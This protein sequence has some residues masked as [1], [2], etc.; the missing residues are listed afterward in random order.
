MPEYPIDKTSN[1]IFQK[2]PILIVI[3][4]SF[5]LCYQHFFAPGE[6][7]PLQPG[8]FSE[9][10]EVPLD[11]FNWGISSYPLKVENYLIF[12]NY[13][14]RAP[15]PQATK[16]YFF[17]AVTGLLISLGITLITTF[18]RY[19]FIGGMGLVIVLLTLSG[20]NALNIGGVSSNLSLIIL[21]VGFTIPGMIIH[22][23]YEHISLL[24]RS[25]IIIPIIWLTIASLLSLS[26][27]MNPALLFSENIGLT[28]LGIAAIFLLY[29]GHAVVGSFFLLL[30]KL[31]RGVGLKISWHITAFTMVY[32][33]LLL[34]I[35]LHHTGSFSLP[36][37]YPPLFPLALLAGYLGWFEVKAKLDQ[38]AQPFDWTIVGSAFYW[39][40]FGITA[41]VFWKADFS[42]NEPMQDF[43]DHWLLYTQ[44]AMS[45]LFFFY[46]MANFLGFMNSGKP[47]D[48][49]IFKPKYFAYLHMRIGSFIALLSLIVYA[50]GVIAPQLSTS[51][52]NFSADYYY[53]T[54][55]PLEARIL[56]ENSWIRY[57][58]NSKAKVATA[59]LYE[60]E[61]QLTLAKQ[62]MEE[63]FEW[64]PSVAEVLLAANMAHKRNRYF[65]ALF[66]LE[67]GLEMFPNN[68][69]I[70]NNL[71]LLYSKSNK[72]QQAL[73]LLED[74]ANADPT[75]LANQIGLQVKHLLRIESM[76]TPGKNK[77]AKI[78]SLAYENVLG[79][80]AAFSLTA[81]PL[82]A[83]L[84]Q[85]AILRNQW[86]NQ[87]TA[88]LAQDI[89]LVDSLYSH[90]QHTAAQQELR[91]TR[92][93]RSYQAHHIG[94]T[95]KYL[96]GLAID[97]NGSA[98]Y[99]HA[100]AA[101]ILT[102]EADFEKA[103]NELEM[104]EMMGFR[105]LK[106]DHLPILYFG[107]K[108]DLSFKIADKYDLEFPKWMATEQ[109]PATNST[110]E[111]LYFGH[112]AGLNKATKV[113]F[114]AQL[115]SMEGGPLKVIFAHE[116]LF[117]K[118]HWLSENEIEKISNYL[119]SH[120]ELDRHYIQE[121]V[122]IAR[123]EMENSPESPLLKAYF[124][125]NAPVSSNPYFTPV[126]LMAA[127]T[128]SSAEAR[129]EL[130]RSAAEF[131]KDPKLW[132]KMIS[133][134]RSLGL[135]G[136]VNAYIKEMR[137]WVPPV[138]LQKILENDH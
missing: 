123:Q 125:E 28:T 73:E 21:I 22:I 116:I 49:V 88:P 18:K 97:F 4:G 56:F 117:K 118:G 115:D 105:D 119:F 90:E 70:K 46:L 135:T 77:I 51:S 131:N 45:L 20:V 130:L 12:Q 41:M 107:G 5:L 52:T 100:L 98:G 102:G 58:R 1:I 111:S 55:R 39:I 44:I 132:G 74:E 25:L 2:L 36:I 35:Y 9:M 24:K 127:K 134:A 93:I 101:Q 64:E 57:R 95:L 65:D 121:L 37:T 6:A 110:Q 138:E 62:Q 104:A 38:I 7:L 83:P 53:A 103:A 96:N 29:V 10:V 106:A 67:K 66:Y 79:N 112:L 40:G 81:E 42:M 91:I 61:N 108:K 114:I 13:E 33:L 63:A 8:L 72:G 80:F 16:T 109:D 82:D 50:D 3:I 129:Y 26:P 76:P 75:M 120:N 137:E 59:L 48:E 126:V 14:V 89:A 124:P 128:A 68:G 54:D 87:T 99:F 69:H 85:Q 15:V 136:Y 30:T 60:G 34:A 113:D 133:A 11:I 86:T 23:F 32:L 71:A 84:I 17:G 94:E 122:S 27:A 19:Y 43:L 31:N 78:N 47:V 92:V